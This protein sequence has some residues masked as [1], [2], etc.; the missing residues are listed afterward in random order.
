MS[1]DLE[2]LRAHADGGLVI[3]PDPAPPSPQED[4]SI[5]KAKTGIC[6]LITTYCPTLTA[7]D[8]NSCEFA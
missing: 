5:R 7:I 3:P 2:T 6:L 4:K 1:P 8:N